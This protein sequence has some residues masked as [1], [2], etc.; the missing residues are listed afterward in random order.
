MIQW[1]GSFV[2]NNTVSTRQV[3][4][5]TEMLLETT[6]AAPAALR[7]LLPMQTE[8]PKDEW[9]GLMLDVAQNRNQESFSAIFDYFAPRVKSYGMALNSQHTS[10]EMADELVQEVMI[11]VWEKAKYFKPEKANVSTWIFAIAR[12]C[13]IDYLR[14]MKRISSPL[15]ADDLWSVYE[16]PEPEHLVDIDHSGAQ[17]EKIVDGLPAEQVAILRE[18]YINGKTHAEVSQQTGVPL[19]TVKSRLR[20]AMEKLKHNLATDSSVPTKTQ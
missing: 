8:K 3:K 14:K 11:K 12:N 16:E 15:S 17:I 13:R 4:I 18:V 1:Q 6:S 9:A 2:N 5:K 7:C 19:G 20:L 10:P